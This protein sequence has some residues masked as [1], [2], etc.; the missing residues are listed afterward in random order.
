MVSIKLFQKIKHDFSQI[1]KKAEV[2]IL[3]HSGDFRFNFLLTK[4]AKDA[5]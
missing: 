4:S 1:S 2:Q 5:I 3:K